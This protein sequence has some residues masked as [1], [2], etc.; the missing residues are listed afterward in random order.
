MVTG[1]YG[2]G[3]LREVTGGYGRLRLE[4]SWIRIRI[5]QI[6]EILEIP[7][8][9]TVTGGYGRLR[10]V[11]GGYGYGYGYGRLREVPGYLDSTDSRDSRDS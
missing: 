4:G 1:D 6:P 11:T 3:R 9:V 5:Y 8:Q 2:Y 10:E 7:R